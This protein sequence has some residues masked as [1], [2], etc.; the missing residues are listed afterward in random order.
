MA[1]DLIVYPTVLTGLDIDAEAFVG[2]T[3][4]GDYCPNDGATFLF[5]ENGA[6]QQVVV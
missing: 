3:A 5:F 6:D 2:A 1:A 4:G